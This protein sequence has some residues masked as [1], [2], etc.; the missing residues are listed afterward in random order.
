MAAFWS[1]ATTTAPQ[2]L[3]V[4]PTQPPTP[5]KNFWRVRLLFDLVVADFLRAFLADDADEAFV[6]R[7]VSRG[8]AACRR[9]SPGAKEWSTTGLS[10]L[11]SML[12][13]TVNKYSSS[14]EILRL[15]TRP[16][17]LSKD[18]VT[19]F[20]AVSLADSAVHRVSVVGRTG[21]ASVSVVR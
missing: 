3:S 20:A 18:S 7:G 5:L 12:S 14:T 6:Q 21:G 9:A 17:P 1:G 19:G 10:P 4:N 11:F 2:Y 16:W 15:N 13:S 8:L